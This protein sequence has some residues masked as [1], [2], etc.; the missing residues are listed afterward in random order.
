[1]SK[2]PPPFNRD[3]ENGGDQMGFLLLFIPLL[4]LL[5]IIAATRAEGAEQ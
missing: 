1:M 5:F 3:R 4:L 2:E